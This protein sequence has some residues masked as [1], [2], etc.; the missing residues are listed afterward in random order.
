MLHCPL[1]AFG[2]N[3]YWNF[4]FCLWL[5]TGAR[6]WPL[7]ADAYLR[8]PLRAVPEAISSARTSFRSP[9]AV[10]SLT[11]IPHV[12]ARA[13]SYYSSKHTRALVTNYAAER[14]P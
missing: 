14:G 11:F 7:I 6:Y 12:F 5:Y 13:R 9:S 4:W 1:P 8:W 2:S 3:Y 10:L